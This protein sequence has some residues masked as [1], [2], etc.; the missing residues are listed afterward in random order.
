MA[1]PRRLVT[2]TIYTSAGDVVTAGRLV[3]TLVPAGGVV[4]DAAGGNVFYKIATG[5]NRLITGTG[6]TSLYVTCLDSMRP[7]GGIFQAQ[8]NVTAP[9]AESW[10]EYWYP[11]F[12]TSGN[13]PL[14]ELI[15]TFRIA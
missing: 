7:R 13:L 11:T 5:Q 8:F 9:Y 1:F 4:P 10:V 12:P 14:A 3:L 15:S 6:I 2:G